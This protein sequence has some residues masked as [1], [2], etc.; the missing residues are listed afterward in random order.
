MIADLPHIVLLQNKRKVLRDVSRFHKF[1]HLVDI[2]VSAE[3]LVI[4]PAAQLFVHFLLRL[5][6]IQQFFK[7]RHQR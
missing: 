7:R 4:H 2:D 5:Q 1:A 6:A 3:F